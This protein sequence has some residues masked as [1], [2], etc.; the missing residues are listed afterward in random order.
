MSKKLNKIN[1]F[2]KSSLNLK[3]AFC[4]INNNEAVILIEPSGYSISILGGF[5]HNIY[6]V[7]LNYKNTHY[8]AFNIIVN[9]SNYRINLIKEYLNFINK[10]SKSENN[11]NIFK[12][13][14]DCN[15]CLY[16]E[17]NSSLLNNISANHN[18]L[19]ILNEV[20][21][22]KNTENVWSES[23]GLGKYNYDDKYTDPIN[24]VDIS[25]W[26]ERFS[27]NCLKE[28]ENKILVLYTL[29]DNIQGPFDE[30]NV[31]KILNSNMFVL[32]SNEIFSNL[33]KIKYDSYKSKVIKGLEDN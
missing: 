4:L 1:C 8:I 12:N 16:Y 3:S 18:V 22:L 17:E 30:Y 10:N 28:K 27:K 6:T 2:F 29:D 25:N 32:N 31:D 5:C 20:W 13:S 11:I 19:L 7:I 9:V 15:L 33:L 14:N 24:F 26:V 21:D 23:C